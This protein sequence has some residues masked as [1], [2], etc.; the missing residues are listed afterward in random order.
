MAYDDIVTRMTLQER[1]GKRTRHNTSSEAFSVLMRM[2][3]GD[4]LYLGA[5]RS[6]TSS[7]MIPPL[8]QAFR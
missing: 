8:Q 3:C 7:Y 1:N 6:L 4:C 5:K 2:R